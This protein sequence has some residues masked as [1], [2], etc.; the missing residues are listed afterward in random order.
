MHGARLVTGMGAMALALS[1]TALAPQGVAAHEDDGDTDLERV[2]VVDDCEPDSFNAAIGDGTC[3]GDGDT[4]F[5]DFIDEL[6]A[7]AP[8]GLASVD[9]WE[10]KPSDVHLDSDEGLLAVNIGGEFH[11]FTPVA[12]FGGG[13]VEE[14]PVLSGGLPPVPE[15]A[16]PD[17]F[18]ETGLPPGAE[19][20]VV[21]LAPGTH[22]FECLIHPWMRTEVVV[23]D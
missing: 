6:L 22:R 18:V 20:E 14:F 10:F 23:R 2:R 12:E 16:E 5:S 1:V 21:D 4:L 7:T 13:C 15:C 9:D 8:S 3:V 17:V 11:T 19:L